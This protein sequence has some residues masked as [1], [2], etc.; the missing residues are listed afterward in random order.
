ME[1]PNC[2]TGGGA[3]VDRATTRRKAVVFTSLN[4]INALKDSPAVDKCSFS[5]TAPP[6]QLLDPIVQKLIGLSLHRPQNLHLS[7]AN[8][9]LTTQPSPPTKYHDGKELKSR[10]G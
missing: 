10:L 1:V 3:S 2:D 5:I 9:Q 4:L 6:R 7:I 8:A